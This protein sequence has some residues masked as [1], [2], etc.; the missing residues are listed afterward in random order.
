MLSLDY[1]QRA[2]SP[3]N[4]IDELQKR[5]ALSKVG[6]RLRVVDLQ[7]LTE[8]QQGERQGSIHFYEMTDARLLMSRF[9]ETLSIV[10]KP[11]IDIAN[12]LTDPNTKIFDD[13]CYSPLAMPG[14]FI[15][16]WQ[17]PTAKPEPGDWSV[18]KQHIWEVICDS[19]EAK[20]SYL[21]KYLA[22]MV[23][24]PEDKPGVMVVLS[25]KQGAGKGVFFECLRRIWSASTV[26][27]S[28]VKDVIG[29]FNSTLE[30][31]YVLILDEAFF[32]GDRGAWDSMKSLITEPFLRIE[33]KYQPQRQVNSLHRIFASTNHR[34]F[35]STT[36]DDRRHFFLS[37]SEKRVA[38]Y[39][40]FNQVSQAINDD[41]VISAML[42][43]LTS[44]DLKGFN[45][46]QFPKSSER[47]AQVLESLMGFDDYWYQSLLSEVI[48][49]SDLY[50]P[51]TYEAGFISSAT[52]HQQ[53]QTYVRTG[54]Y[55]GRV[56]HRMVSDSM[57]RLCP[58]AQQTRGSGSDRNQ[59][60]FVLPQLA[61]ARREFAEALGIDVD[62]S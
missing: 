46:R 18:I 24:R 56:T 11:R 40:Y 19:D 44:L 4:A 38:D 20:Y 23:Q 48:Y 3:T 39:A 61:V 15:N 2:A 62:W 12:F 10:S 41:S 55:K 54:P 59:R 25:S 9:L 34:Q 42:A 43:E 35:G 33:G 8:L 49:N 32:H 45:V 13:V 16:L 50:G 1:T 47:D 14:N 17:G 51:M 29:Q 28:R 6:G 52:L 57:K 22:H 30:N 21:T 31:S 26:F 7:E 5:Y 37:V 27:T 36:S 60:G 58:S 53:A